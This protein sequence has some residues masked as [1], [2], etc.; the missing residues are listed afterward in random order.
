VGVGVRP[1]AVIIKLHD[2]EIEAQING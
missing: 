2:N 1:N